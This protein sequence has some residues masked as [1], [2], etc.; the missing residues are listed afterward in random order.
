MPP[1]AASLRI[2]HSGRRQAA[3]RRHLNGRMERTFSWNEWLLD[4]KVKVL[5]E[6]TEGGKD[7]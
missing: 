7:A 1:F 2:T 4:I 3:C 5:L 6:E